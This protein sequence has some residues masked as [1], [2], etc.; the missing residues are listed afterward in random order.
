MNPLL[1][2]REHFC[3]AI[4]QL[5]KEYL[6]FSTTCNFLIYHLSGPKDLLL[7]VGCL[8]MFNDCFNK[9]MSQSELKNQLIL[10]ILLI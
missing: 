9:Q 10:L 7:H 6:H 2:R 5:P 4:E 1:F 3:I 8:H